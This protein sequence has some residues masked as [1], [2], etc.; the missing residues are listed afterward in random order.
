MATIND[1]VYVDGTFSA[2]NIA[3]GRALINVS[4]DV[5]S[6][7]A[8]TGLTLTGT[9]N[10]YVQATA[11]TNAASART[12]VTAGVRNVSAGSP[13]ESGFTL[14]IYRTTNTNTHVFWM[15]M[16]DPA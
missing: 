8:V 2:S 9:G 13:S 16:R 5:V 15:A 14:Y 11:Y 1:A 6:S 4:A 12:G 3:V 7:V 10:V